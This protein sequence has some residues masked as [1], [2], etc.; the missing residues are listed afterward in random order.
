MSVGR[1]VGRYA[2]YG[3][4]TGWFAL[5]IL[6]QLDRTRIPRRVDPLS[7]LIPNWRFFAPVP[8]RHDFNVLYRVRRA[9]GVVA[10]WRE[11]SFAVR[12]SLLQIFWHPRR[13]IEKAL[14]DVASELFQVSRE[15]RDPEAI[16]LTVSYLSLLNH[17]SHVVAHPD[18]ATEVQFLIARSAEYEPDLEPQLL[19]LSEWHR[20]DDRTPST[21]ERNTA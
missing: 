8:A 13:R 20:L 3:L 9:N 5:S 21:T 1:R 4:F 14:F 15:L 19:F 18:D 2:V 12:R 6:Q 16:Q 10:A 7:M 17:L 11:E